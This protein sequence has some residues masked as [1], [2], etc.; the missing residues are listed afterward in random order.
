M[1]KFLKVS[2]QI[3]L[4]IFPWGIRRILLNKLFSYDLDKNAY[5]GFS[6]VLA[7]K[8]KMDSNSKILHFN[9]CNGISLLSLSQNSTIGTF[10]YITGFPNIKSLHFNHLQ[11]RKCHLV[12]EE[13][14]AITSRHF[15]DCTTGVFIGKFTT[16]AGIRS[17]IF[18]HSINLKRNIQDGKSVYIG[19]YC[20]VG[21]RV[22][23]LPG[24]ILPNFSILGA[25]SL[26]N[27]QFSDEYVLY[28]GNPS[29]MQKKLK[30][31]DYLY[32]SRESGFVY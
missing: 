6:I 28:A 5:I 18:T 17:Q 13:H 19:D 2:I 22:V 8:V 16:I 4:F 15:I 27:K 20:F 29:T 21:T 12:L 14:S 23:V 32:F 30:P 25:A 1:I 3:F 26:L 7:D 31:Q 10:N 9:F 11:N 24:S